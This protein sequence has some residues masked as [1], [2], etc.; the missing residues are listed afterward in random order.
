MRI[1]QVNKLYHPWIGGIETVAQDIAEGLNGREGVTVTNLVCQSRGARAVEQVN[2][3]TTW[4]AASWGIV[5]GMPVS[6]DFFGLFRKLAADADVIV[7][8][9]PFPLAFVAYRLFGRGKTL[10]VWYHSDIVRQRLAKVPFM[11]FIRHALRRAASVCVSNHAIIAHSPELQRRGIAEKCR[12]VYFGIDPARFRETPAIAARAE[13]VR[14]EYGAP[15]ILAVGRLI[16]Y[17]GFLYLIAA[18]KDVA[19]HLVIV[20]SGPMKAALAHEIRELGIG[21]RVHIT[22]PVDDLVPYYH[23]CD[24]FAFPSTESSEVFGIVQLEAMACGKPVVNTALPTGVPE[25]SVDGVTGITVPPRD[26][27]ALAAALNVLLSDKE[28]YGKFSAQARRAVAE[29]FTKRKFVE[30]M[31]EILRDA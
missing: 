25:V 26:A 23:A 3:V 11:P 4:R 12:V 7:L 5:S 30:E 18:M 22:G 21:D 8:H 6:L 24:I 14:K 2:G 28:K 17:K 10:V 15:L 13:A 29:R 16:Y 20:G 31:K 27:Q 19:A 9:H 1:L